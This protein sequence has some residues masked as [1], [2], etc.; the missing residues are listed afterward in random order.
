MVPY[1]DDKDTLSE[2]LRSIPDNAIVLVHQGIDSADMGHYILDT[3]SLD[4]S[5]F[6]RF[7]TIGS[8]YHKRQ[9]IDCNT[10]VFSYLGNLYTLGYGEANDPEKGFQILY[11]DG[12]LEFVPT[13]LRKHVVINGVI[14]SNGRVGYEG[15]TAKINH[16][17]I[18]W[19]K[20]SGPSDQL[21]KHNKAT[22]AD[23]FGLT[24]NFRLDLIPTDTKS[25]KAEV[26][27]EMPQAELLDSLIDSLRNTDVSRKERLKN[28]WKALK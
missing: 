26:Q 9:D 7:R 22:L 15:S 6:S 14:N 28:L 19:L 3:T 10:G 5:Y 21:A 25:E 1:I 12:S 13:N 24:G 8:H 17:D 11:D 27:A 20:L 18:I 2:A 4:K 16:D 23:A